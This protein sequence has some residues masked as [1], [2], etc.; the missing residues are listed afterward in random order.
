VKN[1]DQLVETNRAPDQREAVERG[2]WTTK[3]K[4]GL[5]KLEGQ[6][7]YQEATHVIGQTTTDYDKSR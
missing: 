3:T 2:L 1:N 5:A 4:P 7:E 6:E